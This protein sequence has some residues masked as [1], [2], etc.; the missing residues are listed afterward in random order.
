MTKKTHLAFPVLLLVLVSLACSRFQP[1]ASE[2]PLSGKI[3]Y[4]SDQN[5]NFDLYSIDVHGGVPARLTD[6]SA[7]DVSPT[8]IAATHQIG[9]SSDRENNWNIYRMDMSGKNIQKVI[10]NKDVVAD[11]PDWSPDGKFIAASLVEKCATTAASCNYDIYTLNADGTQLKNLTNTPAASE[12]VPAWSPDG[13]KIA[14]SSDRD[15]DAEI[16]VMNKDGSHLVKLTDNH[17]YDGRPRWSPDGKQIAFETDRDGVDWDIY[18]MNADGS[19]PQAVTV[20]TTSDFSE[21]WSPDGNWLVYV[22]NNDGDNE[23][24][25]IDKNGQRQQ[26]LTNNTYNDKSPT[27]VP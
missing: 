14:F 11:Y 17:G 9:F 19:N 18:I 10:N 13:Q 16:Y 24:F 8:Y 15:G 20:N 4:Q 25:I 26:R 2:P 3:V 12:W 23:I 22:S 21:S 7:N 5:G 1:G 27:W 6:T